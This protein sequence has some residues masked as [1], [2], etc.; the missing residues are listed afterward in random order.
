[1]FNRTDIVIKTVSKYYG[2]KEKGKDRLLLFE[3]K[4]SSILTEREI[5]P[6]V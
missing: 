6:L 2:D 3:G 1:M 4:K 5:I